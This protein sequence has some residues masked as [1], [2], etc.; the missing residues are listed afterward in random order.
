[1]IYYKGEFGVEMNLNYCSQ[2]KLCN[3]SNE[4]NQ[5][6]VKKMSPILFAGQVTKDLEPQKVWSLFE[7][8]TKISRGS[9]P[10]AWGENNKEISNYL[11]DKLENAGFKVIQ[12]LDDARGKYNLYAS[13]N[14]DPAKRNAIIL[15]AH[16]DIVNVSADGNHEKP[17]QL[18]IDK[19]LN[20]KPDILRA[21][22]RTLGAD[23][24]IGLAVAL[25]IGENDKYKDLPL[26]IIFTVNEE[27]GMHGAKAMKASDFMGNYLINLDSEEFG[28]IIIGCAGSYD[29]KVDKAIPV[30][31][32]NNNNYH[33]ITFSI[34]DAKGGHS[35]CD[36]HKNRINVIRAATELLLK[37][38]Q[39]FN[40]RIKAING[41]EKRNSIPR[42]VSIEIL[43]PP[44]ESEKLLKTI[45][46]QL[47]DIQKSQKQFS[48][49]M[50][51]SINLSDDNVS[52]ETLVID[53][54]FQDRFL[55]VIGKDLQVGAMSFYDENNVK[56]SQNLGLLKLD[57]G[58]LFISALMRGSDQKEIEAL[59]DQTVSNLSFLYGDKIK[60]IS[61][62]PIWQPKV[63]KNSSGNENVSSKLA[64]LANQAY[65]E[66]GVSKPKLVTIHAGLENAYFADLFTKNNLDVD[67]ISVG[68]DVCNPHTDK[69]FVR[70]SSVKGFYDFINNLLDKLSRL[71]GK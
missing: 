57:N 50:K 1:M 49:E 39:Y 14:V 47:S 28:E 67:Q 37:N 16:M 55:K 3:F 64:L 48:P 62:Y 35:G 4:Y 30:E 46:K 21:N 61:S 65:K 26:Q 8:I 45:S 56:T 22:D 13:R 40:F 63:E 29:F 53:K 34:N 7:E 11:K 59:K 41:G 6:K 31:K 38:S 2:F 25:A 24:G 27:N 66:T 42:N 15:Q 60:P 32:T 71:T 5:V 9:D 18:I 36:I 19:D 43:S 54:S 68:P 17:I 58:N 23:D 44:G 20:D 52:E 12:M 33:T 69:E 51:V 70:I 10:E